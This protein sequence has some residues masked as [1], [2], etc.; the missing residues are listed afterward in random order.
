MSIDINECLT[1][2]GGCKCDGS[3]SEESIC[4]VSCD[5]INGSHACHCSQ[6]Y[7]LN[8]DNTTCIGKQLLSISLMIIIFFMY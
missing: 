5:N 7:I 4:S 3:L 8:T 6:G 1:N 2:N